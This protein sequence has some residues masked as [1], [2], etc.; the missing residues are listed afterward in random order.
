MTGTETYD[1]MVTEPVAPT[2]AHGEIGYGTLQGGR[3]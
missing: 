3:P 2:S 1:S